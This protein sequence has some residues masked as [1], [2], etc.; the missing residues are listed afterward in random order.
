MLKRIIISIIVIALF[1]FADT[2]IMKMK[3][4]DKLQ[5]L[6]KAKVM[7][8]KKLAKKHKIKHENFEVFM[9]EAYNRY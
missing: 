9:L 2:I 5:I 4:Q 8:Q 6:R 7:S 1:Y 3:F